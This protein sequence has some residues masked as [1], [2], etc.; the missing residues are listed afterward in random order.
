MVAAAVQWQ[1]DNG[2]AGEQS[3]HVN[4]PPPSPHPLPMALPHAQPRAPFGAPD[5]PELHRDD[6]EVGLGRI[7]ASEIEA[8]NMLVNLV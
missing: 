7:V 6:L 8:P 2:R 5:S 1:A 3:V 4:G